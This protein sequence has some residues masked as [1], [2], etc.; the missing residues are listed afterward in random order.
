LEEYSSGRGEVPLSRHP[1]WLLVLARG[2]GHTSY[3]LEVTEG[4]KTR[5]LLALAYVRSLLFG[6][7]LVSLP[8]LKGV[9]QP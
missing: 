1:G 7:F 4:G 9:P 3:C 8:Y 5:G 6:R 2:L